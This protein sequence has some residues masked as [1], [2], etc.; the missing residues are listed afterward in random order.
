MG[1][2]D[3]SSPNFYQMKAGEL[4]ENNKLKTG[5][6]TANVN[7]ELETVLYIC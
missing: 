3:E 6:K 5:H 7:Y 4:K 2:L 1:L